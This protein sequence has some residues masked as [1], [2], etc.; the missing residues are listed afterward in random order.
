ME[1]QRLGSDTESVPRGWDSPPNILMPSSHSILWAGL[2]APEDLMTPP[3]P[4][5][6]FGSSPTDAPRPC[7]DPDGLGNLEWPCPKAWGLCGHFL[8]PFLVHQAFLC[9]LLCQRGSEKTKQTPVLESSPLFPS[10]G[11]R[12]TQEVPGS[13]SAASGSL[14]TCLGG[15]PLVA[16]LISPP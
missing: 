9:P 12:L 6:F 1:R 8:V 15:L 10:Q 3:P 5:A 11:C 7:G 16:G 4:L 2:V 14:S 13:F